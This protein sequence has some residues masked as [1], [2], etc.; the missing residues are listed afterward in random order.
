YFGRFIGD[1]SLLPLRTKIQM[2]GD[3]MLMG[4][5]YI[6][7]GWKLPFAEGD[8]RALRNFRVGAGWRRSIVLHPCIHIGDQRAPIP[9]NLVGIMPLLGSVIRIAL[10]ALLRRKGCGKM[11]QPGKK[12]D[13]NIFR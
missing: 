13:A 8:E 4:F 10:G 7:Y 12:V 6:F 5:V 9:A 1:D 2:V 3:V 11:L